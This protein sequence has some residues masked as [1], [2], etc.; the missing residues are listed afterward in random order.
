[1]TMDCWICG[2]PATTGEHKTK[3][4]DLRTSLGTP[5]QARPFYYHDQTTRNRQVRSYKADFLKS[6]SRLCAKCNNERTQP[7]DRAWERL[8]IWLRTRKPPIK[9]EDIIRAN[10]IFPYQ[11]TTKMRRV[12]LYFAKLTGCH[13]MEANLKFDVASLSNSILLGKINPHIYLKF[14]LYRDEMIGMSDLH[15]TTL[16]T[17]N[18]CAFA[19]WF[20]QVGRLAVNVMYAIK[21]E[22]R[23][24]LVGAWHPSSGT[25]RFVVADFPW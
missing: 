17:D 9:P 4:S 24:G 16:A 14:G 21:G 22:S 20:Y 23:E 25:N 6:A 8:S 11:T 18:S 12:Q 13:L 19:T 2:D 15:A 5:T 3:Q 1:M 7:Y 10:R